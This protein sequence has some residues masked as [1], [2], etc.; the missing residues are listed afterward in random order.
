MSMQIIEN[1]TSYINSALEP[2]SGYSV[3]GN[4]GADYIIALVIFVVSTAVFAI[5]QKIVVVRLEKLAD[6]TSTDLDDTLISIV[7]GVRPA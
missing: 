6:K 7:R 4:T 2:F 3:F 1:S 5:V